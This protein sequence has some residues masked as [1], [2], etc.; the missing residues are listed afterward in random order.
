[1]IR[2]NWLKILA[3]IGEMARLILADCGAG[4]AVSRVEIGDNASRPLFS[5]PELPSSPSNWNLM[6]STILGK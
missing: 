1:M 6:D 5:F 3:L 2:C 4:V